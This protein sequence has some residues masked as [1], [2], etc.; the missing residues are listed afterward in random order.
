VDDRERR[1]AEN[2]RLFRDVNE[3]IE[4]VAAGQGDDEH[5]YE[6][7]C[8]CSNLDCDLMLSVRLAEYER[9]RADPAVFIVAAGHELPEIEEVVDRTDRYQLVRKLGEAARVAEEDD[10]RRR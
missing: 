8:E 6:F 1:L 7:L 2:E 9:A 5:E 10:P 3:E 4:R